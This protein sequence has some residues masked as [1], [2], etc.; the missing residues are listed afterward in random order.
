MNPFLQL[1][2]R[3]TVLTFTLALLSSTGAC[4][5]T[6]TFDKKVAELDNVRASRD[7]VVV[8]RDGLRKKLDDATAL[9][10]EFTMRPQVL[11]A[12]GASS[13]EPTNRDCAAAEPYR[14]S[15]AR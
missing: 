14:S 1:T 12:A 9:V 3:P 8:E 15:L 7:H 11:A 4:V 10:G 5:T 13:P 2:L 6:G